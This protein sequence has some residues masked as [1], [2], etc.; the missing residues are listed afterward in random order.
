MTHSMDHARDRRSNNPKIRKKSILWRHEVEKHGG[1]E[2]RFEMKVL[3]TFNRD[4]LGK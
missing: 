4:P 3:A 1:R 2:A